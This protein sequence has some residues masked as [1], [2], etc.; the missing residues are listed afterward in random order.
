MCG[1]QFMPKSVLIPCLL[2]SFIMALICTYKVSS[3][4]ETEISLV[5]QAP[6][7]TMPNDGMVTANDTPDKKSKI[8]KYVILAIALVFIVYG[9][10]AGGTMDVLTKAVNICTECI[11]LG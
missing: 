1:T 7:K 8:I 2:A 10:F 3:L 9:L 6:R 5:K 4:F 11:G